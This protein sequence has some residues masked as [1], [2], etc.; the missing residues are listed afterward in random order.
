MDMEAALRAQDELSYT[1]VRP[2]AFFKSVSGQVEV[3]KGGGPFVYFD[4][5]DGKCASCNPIS[6]PD[7]ASALVDSIADESRLGKL[8]VCHHGLLHISARLTYRCMTAGTLLKAR[9]GIWG[10][11]TR[12]C[13]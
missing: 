13:P 9:C 11:R 6:E 10:V 12:A 7:L 3:V 4:L 2:T 8:Y 1:I 5:G